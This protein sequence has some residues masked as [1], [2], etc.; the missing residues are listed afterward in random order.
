[1]MDKL[2]IIVPGWRM[3]SDGIKW[4]KDLGLKYAE[5]DVNGDTTPVLSATDDIISAVKEYG[6]SIGAVGRWGRKRLNEDLT[7]NGDE[8][9]AEYD[10][11]DFCEKVGC[12]VYMTGINYVNGFSYFSNITAA[13]NYFENLIKY[14]DGR[15]KICTYNCEWENYVNK[16]HEWDIVHGH[17]KELGIKFDPSHTINGGRDY[18]SEIVHYGDRVYHIHLKGTI[19]I[20]GIHLD[21]PPAGLDSVNWPAFL[22]A[23]RKFGYDGMLSIEPHSATWQGEIGEKGLQYTIR[24]M[25]NLLFID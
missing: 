24:Y 17:L 9:K 10:L 23:F 19:N 7:V 21:D 11:I 3:N 1:M 4:V 2:G 15:V 20:D 12:P 13:V 5:F 22:S 18:L 6:V 25:K 8:L 16:P 14:S